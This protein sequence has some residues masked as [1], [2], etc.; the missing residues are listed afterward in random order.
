MEGSGSCSTLGASITPNA[1]GGSD[2]KPPPVPAS[3]TCSTLLHHHLA[4]VCAAALQRPALLLSRH[5]PTRIT[6]M[7]CP[8]CLNPSS[9]TMGT[10]AAL[11]ATA[12]LSLMIVAFPVSGA[13][14][15]ILELDRPLTGAI[16]ISSETMRNLLISL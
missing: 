5:P 15:L 4:S 14:F 10:V 6:L 2:W 11:N 8:M 16:R 7:P 1:P 9:H 3:R 13:L 12:F